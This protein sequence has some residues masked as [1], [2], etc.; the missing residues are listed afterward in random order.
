MQA[1]ADKINNDYD[2][3]AK[4]Y[5]TVEK[6]CDDMIKKLQDFKE[7]FRIGQGWIL[8]AQNQL[9]NLEIR[10]LTHNNPTMQQKFDELKE[11]K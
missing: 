3:A 1:I 2:Y 4:Q 6:M 11:N 7:A 5:E 10:K 8:K 9:P